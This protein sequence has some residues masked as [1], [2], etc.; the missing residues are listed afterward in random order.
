VSLDSAYEK[1]RAVDPA[2]LPEPVR[3]LLVALPT[4]QLVLQPDLAVKDWATLPEEAPY[5]LFPKLGIKSWRDGGSVRPIARGMPLRPIVQGL[6]RSTTPQQRAVLGAWR[7]ASLP[8]TLYFYPVVDF[9]DVTE[10]RWLARPGGVEFVSAC[11]RGASAARL[12]AALGDLQ[13][14]AGRIAD[15]LPERSHIIELA[16]SP[17]GQMRLV[18]VNPALEPAELD[19]VLAAG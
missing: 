12:G 2:A 5:N 10:V 11:Q 15:L 1:I 4:L 17:G 3:Q 8:V 18:E 6:L 19:A 16:L 9:S 7:A 14:L 13:A